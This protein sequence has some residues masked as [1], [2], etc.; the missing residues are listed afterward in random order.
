M[1]AEAEE[2][3]QNA[4]AQTP[5]APAWQEDAAQLQSEKDALQEE[6]DMLRAAARDYRQRFKRL[7][8]DQQHVLNAETELFE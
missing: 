7:V 2:M 1:R 4:P 8:E 5:V 3:L 6:I